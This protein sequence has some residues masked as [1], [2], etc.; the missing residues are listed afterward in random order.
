MHPTI[1]CHD[2]SETEIGMFVATQS[3]VAAAKFDPLS[4]IRALHVY[5]LGFNKMVDCCCC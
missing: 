4:N 1:I 3:A 5:T 2:Q